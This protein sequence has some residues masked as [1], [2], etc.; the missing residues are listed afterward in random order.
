MILKL[1]GLANHEG[2]T[3]KLN[4]DMEVTNLGVSCRDTVSSSRP[5]L[6]WACY[7]LHRSLMITLCCD[8]VFIRSD[9]RDGSLHCWKKAWWLLQV[10]K[11]ILMWRGKVLLTSDQDI[12][13]VFALHIVIRKRVL[14][15][16][17]VTALNEGYSRFENII[18]AILPLHAVTKHTWAS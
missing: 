17:Q 3:I 12:A 8:L 6:Y 15:K 14:D 9:L 16:R 7:R 10:R 18:A 13:K 11:W 5:S 4:L 2:L 1:R